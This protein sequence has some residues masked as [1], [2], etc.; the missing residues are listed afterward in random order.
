MN[1]YRRIGCALSFGLALLTVAFKVALARHPVWVERFYSRGLFVM[2]RNLLD[3]SFGLLPVPAVSVLLVLLAVWMVSKLLRGIFGGRSAGISFWAGL[4]RFVL[5]FSAI[6]ALLLF[7]FYFLWGFNYDRLPV[8]TRLGLDLQ[9]LDESA[10]R[11]EAVR[12]AAA[13]VELRA[14]II[15]AGPVFLAASL[16]PRNL[17]GTLRESFVRVLGRLGY[18]APGRVRLRFFWP[19]GLLMRLD[20]AGFYFPLSGEA[21]LPDTLCPDGLPFAAA[22]EMAHAYGFAEEGAANFIALL[23]CLD[24]REPIVRYSGC[25][26]YFHYIAPELRRVSP[27]EYKQLFASLSPGVLAD[28]RHSYENW[29]RYKSWLSDFGRSVNNLYLKSQG[30]REGIRSYNRLLLLYTAYKMRMTSLS[31]LRAQLII[32]CISGARSS[33][34]V[35]SE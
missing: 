34:L 4:G 22:H 14:G 17:E 21:V 18:P 31:Y 32:S 25:M 6:C 1:R 13:L 10:I 9:P 11:R 16:L 3:Y 15:G 2:V 28:L 5:R 35:V 23:V 29:L 20:V 12:T 8:E 27:A 30:I 26:G 33:P 7:L 19:G 24:S